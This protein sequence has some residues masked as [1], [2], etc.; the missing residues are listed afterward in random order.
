MGYAK[1][2]ITMES[3]TGS[4]SSGRAFSF[5]PEVRGQALKSSSFHHHSSSKLTQS[6]IKDHMVS[7]YKK[8][9]SAKAAVDTSVPKSLLHS[10][11][12]K[13][14]IRREQQ[15]KDGRPQSAYSFPQRH[16]RASC[17][18]A[19]YDD[20][21]YLCSRSSILSS[22]RFNTSFNPNETVYPSFKVSS[23]HTRAASETKYRSPDVALQ[24]KHSASSLAALR[25]QHGFQTFQDPIQKTYS[26]DLLQKHSQ[27]FTQEKPFT[28][29]TLK[30]ER[31]SYLSKYRFYRAPQRKHV[32]DQKPS[33]RKQETHHESTNNMDYN[34]ELDEPSQ[35][36][37][38]EHEW[39]EDEANDT[40]LSGRLSRTTKSRD[41]LLESLSRASPEDNKSA[42]SQVSA[43]EEELM[44][45]EFISAVTKDILSRGHIS[46]RVIDRVMKRHIEMNLHKLDEGK[47]Q[48]LL[49][50]LHKELE[51]P[52]NTFLPSKEAESREN[53]MVGAIF[54]HLDF[55]GKHR[56][57]KEEDNDLFPYASFTKP[58]I[59]TNGIDFLSSTPVCSPENTTTS[60]NKLC[61]KFNENVREKSRASFCLSSEEDTSDVGIGQ[62]D[63]DQVDVP[64]SN[65]EKQKHT[66]ESSDTSILSGSQSKELDDLGKGL[67]EWRL[68]SNT[69][70]ET[71]EPTKEQHKNSV[72]DDEF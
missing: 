42:F 27:C 13:D 57:A 32:Q 56:K 46:N 49:E 20:S 50:V 24:R 39:T 28:P 41:C 25:D 35:E 62:Q 4:V 5:S 3:R 53:D 10:V 48:H 18:S 44:Y 29:K 11:K 63:S 19:Q 67:S 36:Y 60:S 71:E 2:S 8:I 69:H 15:R 61:G 30:S 51:D 66:S 47:M 54:S 6:I 23:H 38:T 70:S 64:E 16:S 52:S 26:G 45:L 7:H 68:S 1:L 59:L 55:E 9:Y 21:P 33:K 31:S 14:Q 12:Y 65:N 72:S 22:P 17:S 43:E 34:E 58:G 37:S 40:Q